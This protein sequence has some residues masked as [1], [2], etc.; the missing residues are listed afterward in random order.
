[1]FGLCFLGRLLAQNEHD[2]SCSHSA[3][4]GTRSSSESSHALDIARERYAR[5]EI[6]KAEFDRIK[7]DLA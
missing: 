3:A 1:M 7:R 6:D 5:G 4:P 2:H